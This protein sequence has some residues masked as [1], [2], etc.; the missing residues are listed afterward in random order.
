[1]PPSPY[2]QA[3]RDKIGNDL[4]M[5]QSVTVMLFDDRGRLLLAQ[6]ASSELWMTVGG[7][8][9]PDERPADAAVRECWEETGLL[10]E[11]TRVL[12]VFGGPE[13]RIN[14]PNGDAV[15]Y[16][17]TVFEARWID[18][19]ASPDGLE[20]SALRFVAREEAARL[21]MAPWTK[22]MVTRAFEHNGM[23]YF[24]RPTWQPPGA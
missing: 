24:A 16:V 11:P 22:E 6:D 5:L 13:F 12:G 18:G 10:V 17:V 14:Y 21:P 2:V 1:M 3:V 23:P 7:A 9:D 8:I 15:S 20:A 4:L 19:D